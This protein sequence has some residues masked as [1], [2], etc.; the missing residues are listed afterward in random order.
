MSMTKLNKRYVLIVTRALRLSHTSPAICL[1]ISSSE[2]SMDRFV[3]PRIKKDTFIDAHKV[4]CI[5]G[6]VGCGK[7]T[8]AKNNLDYIEVDEDILRS[9]ES[10]LEFIERIRCLK[11]NILIDNFDG[12]LMTPGAPLFMNA[13]ITKA[14]TILISKTYIPGTVPHEL[15]GPDYRQQNIGF[16]SIDLFE[17]YPDIIKRHLTTPGASHID[18]I[19]T[20]QSEHGNV[21]GI[22]HENVNTMDPRVFESF[23]DADIIDT[24]MY[25]DGLWNL[26]PYFVNSACVIPCSLIDGSIREP[27]RSATLWTKHM[28][29]CMNL[30]LFRG[31]R[32]HLDVIDFLHR[33]QGQSFKF[34][35]FKKNKRKC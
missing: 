32:L 12:L 34:Y 15:T 10:S 30:K 35:K 8:W 28:N 11:R 4:I 31:T 1:V 25:D 7:T 6:P 2:L 5:F 16:D 33:V 19:R 20:I 18:L 26:I 17:D 14:S 29:T 9:K 22:V 23:S 27:I 3:L 21:M 13:P 24:K